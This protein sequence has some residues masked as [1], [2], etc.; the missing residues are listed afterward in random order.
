MDLGR[1][2]AH[3]AQ[4]RLDGRVLRHRAFR[5]VAHHAARRIAEL[6]GGLVDALD[7]LLLHSSS[8]DILLSCT[9]IS[10]PPREYRSINAGAG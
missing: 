3:L 10:K 1:L 4:L 9:I 7:H 6:V 8:T 2:L 5:R